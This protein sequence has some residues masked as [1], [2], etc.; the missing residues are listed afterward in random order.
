MT[1]HTAIDQMIGQQVR[2]WEVLDQPILDAMRR[3]PREVFV[4]APWRSV[5][6][7]DTAL[8]L[9]H[10]KHMLPPMLV[11]RILTALSPREGEQVLE[12]GTGSGYLGACMAALGAQVQSLELHA[13]LAAQARNNLQSAGIVGVEVVQADG[14]SVHETARHDCVVLT[15]SLPIWQPQFAA[16]LRDGGR[17]F[18]VV[19]TGPVMEAV[20]IERLGSNLRRSVL[21]E[22]SLE[23]LENAPRPP[24]FR[25]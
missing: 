22:T 21:F 23:A 2:T 25:F 20:L 17:L 14:M 6:F 11:G 3:V 15:A 9:G 12:V 10:G 7:A 5:A 24:A 18:A 8:P 1:A 19:G 16:A 13:D 4:P